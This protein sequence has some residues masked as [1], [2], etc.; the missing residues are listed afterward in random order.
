M[1]ELQREHAKSVLLFGIEP[2]GHYLFK[3]A[4]YLGK[5]GI[6]W[7]SLIRIMCTKAKN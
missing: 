6:P 4:E 3:L 7:S 5:Q 1:K 2:T